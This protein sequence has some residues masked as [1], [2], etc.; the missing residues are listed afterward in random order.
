[1]VNLVAGP[2]SQPMFQIWCKYIQK[3]PTY[4][5]KCDISYGGRRHLGFWKIS[6]LL[7][8]PVTGP[9]FL[10]LRQIWCE[11]V[12]KW[13]IY[14]HLTDFKMVAAAILDFWPM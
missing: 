2:H 14:G 5:Q 3:R 10:S 13:S 7:I 12:Q 6:L 8:K 11:S 1:M 9:R 4:G